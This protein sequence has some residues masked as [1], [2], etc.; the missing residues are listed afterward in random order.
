M[1]VMIHRIEKYI[2]GIGC[3][4]S[5]ENSDDDVSKPGRDEKCA[6]MKRNSNILRIGVELMWKLMKT[7]MLILLQTFKPVTKN[8][9]L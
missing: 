3:H 1:T 2:D 4:D 6:M 5:A 8:K 7:R 9:M